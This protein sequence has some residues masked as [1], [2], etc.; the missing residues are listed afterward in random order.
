MKSRATLLLVLF[1]F[2]SGCATSENSKNWSD[3]NQATNYPMQ[4]CPESDLTA[5][6]LDSDLPDLVLPCLGHDTAVNLAGLPTGK[7]L[8]VSLWASWCVYC[9]DDALAFIAAKNKFKNLNFIGINY[10]D[11]DTAAVAS[12][13]KWK[14]PFPS[15]VDSATILQGFYQISGLPVTLIYDENGKLLSRINGPIGTP[16]EF[17]NY[18]DELLK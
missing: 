1:V 12:A 16:E 13:A 8:V 2:M 10:Q 7:P 14:L 18:L 3:L 15:V 4:N 5:V 9:E 11:K 17:T 6:A